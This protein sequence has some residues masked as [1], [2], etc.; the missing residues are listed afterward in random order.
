M[1]FRKPSVG[2]Y[3]SLVPC[4]WAYWQLF[5]AQNFNIHDPADALL[6]LA[7]YAALV[8]AA[9]TIVASAFSSKWRNMT[10]LAG[11]AAV[12]AVHATPMLVFAQ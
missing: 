3:L 4:V 1:Q 8:W 11:A 7:Y 12:V 5:W 10:N 6:M 9:I 2:F